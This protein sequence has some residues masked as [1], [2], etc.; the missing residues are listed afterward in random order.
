MKETL[1][2]LGIFC[3]LMIY[4]FVCI[5]IYYKKNIPNIPIVKDQYI[6]CCFVIL[7]PIAITTIFIAAGLGLGK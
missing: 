3:F 5:Y 4:I 1:F 6:F 7:C 2:L